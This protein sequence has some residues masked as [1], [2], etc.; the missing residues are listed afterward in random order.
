MNLFESAAHYT[1][2]ASR[3]PIRDEQELLEVIYHS[4]MALVALM[5]LVAEKL[6]EDE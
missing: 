1:K 6:Y 2:L 5:T 3:L 4:N